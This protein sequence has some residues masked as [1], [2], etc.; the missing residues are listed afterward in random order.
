V[1]KKHSLKNNTHTYTHIHAR[2]RRSALKCQDEGSTNGQ[3]SSI[4]IDY[5]L[6]ESGEKGEATTAQ[7]MERKKTPEHL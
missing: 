3:A 2:R 7:K 1:K 4:A 6:A 5:G